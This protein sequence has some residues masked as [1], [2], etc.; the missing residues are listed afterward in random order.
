MKQYI[1]VLMIFLN[2]CDSEEKKVIQKEESA[3]TNEKNN[4][5]PEEK[6]IS[7]CTFSSKIPQTLQN[8][9]PFNKSTRVEA[10]HFKL[11]NNFDSYDSFAKIVNNQLIL[12][13]IVRRV[14]LNPS[15]IKK[16]FQVLYQYQ[17][18]DAEAAKCYDPEHILVFYEGQK[19]IAFLEI[20]FS[21]HNTHQKNT[22]FQGFCNEKWSM[23]YDFFE[24]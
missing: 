16:L 12:R 1:F 10:I 21:C 7:K 5:L 17:G 24:K 3:T 14:D 8:T 4:H 6:N 20:C 13:N 11:D 22:D 9:F 18:D 19:A 15:Q 2:A 23:L